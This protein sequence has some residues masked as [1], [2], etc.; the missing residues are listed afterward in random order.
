MSVVNQ[1]Y[2]NIE[3]IIVDDASTDNSQLV[4]EQLLDKGV[5]AT[6]LPLE[7]NIGNCR[8]FNRGLALAN[9]EY[10][11]DHATDDI[12]TPQRISKQVR[13]FTEL[14][15]RYGVVYTNAYYIDE[16]GEVY[17]NHFKHLKKH[18]LIGEIPEGDV[19]AKVLAS[20]FIPSPTV[21]FRMEV[22]Q[23][24]NGYDE[25]LAYEDFDFWV[26]SSRHYK[27]GYVDEPLTK[28]RKLKGSLSS[29]WYVPGDKQLKSTY[30]ICEK[31]FGML[32]NKGETQALTARLRFEFRTSVFSENFEEAD[33]FYKLLKK[34]GGN[35]FF[36]SCIYLLSKLR[37]PL[38][39]PRNLYQQL[40]L[41]R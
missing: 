9:G 37:V 6:Y 28:I 3:V 30:K 27:Y 35:T 23:M 5:E 1:E 26:R 38:S 24:L 32:Q 17:R 31:A 22:I 29:S 21:M 33:M 16:K 10:V 20:Y 19:F 14:G 7:N 15:G 34:V 11:V 36:Y 40:R 18:G 8:A 25:S 39:K 2:D 12:M 41:G 4:I 13:R